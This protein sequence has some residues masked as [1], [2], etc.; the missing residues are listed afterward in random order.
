MFSKLDRACFWGSAP[1]DASQIVCVIRG[2]EEETVSEAT[3]E[4]VFAYRHITAV[5]H[6]ISCKPDHDDVYVCLRGHHH[7]IL[8]VMPRVTATDG[9]QHYAASGRR[10]GACL[11]KAAGLERFLDST[12]DG[13][14]SAL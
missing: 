5:V 1:V 8:R 13:C 11:P 10:S 3:R 7:D 6:S 2:A 12:G 9:E 4:Q 14:T